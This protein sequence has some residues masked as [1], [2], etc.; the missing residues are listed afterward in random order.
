MMTVAKEIN[1]KI[2]TKRPIALPIDR[3]I[4]NM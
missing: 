2:A 4:L 1:T 3:P